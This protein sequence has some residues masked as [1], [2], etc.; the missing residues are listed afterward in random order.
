MRFGCGRLR[1]I[2]SVS[3]ILCVGASG[4]AKLD[5]AKKKEAVVIR[6]ST[7][8]Y[9]TNS[10][11]QNKRFKTKVIETKT[12][13][14]A[15]KP[16]GDQVVLKDDEGSG[17]SQLSENRIETETISME[18]LEKR[19]KNSAEFRKAYE[20]ALRVELE[21]RAVEI[22]KR[23]ASQEKEVS[24]DEINRYSQVRGGNREELKVEAAGGEK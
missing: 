19:L 7:S 4:V 8:K 12:K 22:S 16:A 11:L 10:K 13:D 20:E 1:G 17:A 5:V 9:E 3:A 15:V 14:A 24:Q 23:K 21:R 2:V 6:P 18:V